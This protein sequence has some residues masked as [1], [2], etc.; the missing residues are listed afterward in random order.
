MESLELRVGSCLVV[1]LFSCSVSLCVLTCFRAIVL[2]CLR[3]YDRWT[4]RTDGTYTP[5]KRS[6]SSSRG[7]KADINIYKLGYK[8]LYLCGRETA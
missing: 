1:Q 7:G 6:G 3:T 2:S 8:K 5:P 4:Y